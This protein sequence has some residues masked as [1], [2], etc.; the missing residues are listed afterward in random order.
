MCHD[1]ADGLWVRAALLNILVNDWPNCLK[2]IRFHEDEL[3]TTHL[4]RCRLILYTVEIN[5]TYGM[6]AVHVI[7]NKDC[8]LLL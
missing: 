4:S 6:A 1:S 5:F 2:Y 7:I 8:F 3:T